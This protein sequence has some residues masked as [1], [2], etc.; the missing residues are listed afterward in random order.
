[1]KRNV[2]IVILLLA[3]MLLTAC[4]APVEPQ[5][6][7][8]PTATD[9]AAPETPLTKPEKEGDEEP[10]K[11]TMMKI[12]IGDSVLMAEF[13]DTVAA[14]TLKEKLE[15]GGVTIAAFNYGGWEKVGGLPW[16]LPASDVQTNAVLGDI[17]LYQGNSIVLFYG[18]NRWAYTRLGTI[19]DTDTNSLAQI[20]GGGDSELTL[21]L[22]KE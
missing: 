16:N 4:T 22:T 14:K 9:P 5:D 10:M 3:V 20:L 11:T 2:G 17:M 13:A 21:S 6:A 19:V 7:P 1:M 8:L 18:S 15:E 12:E